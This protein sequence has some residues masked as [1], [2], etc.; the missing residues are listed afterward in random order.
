MY[1]ITND[2][3][4]E[5]NFSDERC[6]ESPLMAAD[7]VHSLARTST[8]RA[9][10]VC[11]SRCFV[12]KTM[13]GGRRKPSSESAA[14]VL[15][16]A[17]CR[18][19]PPLLCSAYYLFIT[20]SRVGT[21]IIINQHPTQRRLHTKFCKSFRR[22]KELLQ[23]LAPWL[24]R[25]R[26]INTSHKK[27]PIRLYRPLL[28]ELE[29]RT[30]SSRSRKESP[31][32][33]A[34]RR[35]DNSLTSDSSSGGRCRISLA[36]IVAL[37][38]QGGHLAEAFQTS[39]PKVSST[40]RTRSRPT[41]LHAAYSS[42]VE[43][44]QILPGLFGH[45]RAASTSSGSHSGASLGI[46]MISGAFQSN[47]MFLK[48]S[49]VSLQPISSLS[50]DFYDS[51]TTLTRKPVTEDTDSA[52]VSLQKPTRSRG[53]LGFAILDHGDH[54][55]SSSRV[56]IPMEESSTS[57]KASSQQEQQRPATKVDVQTWGGK[58][59]DSEWIASA[60]HRESSS[61]IL[62]RSP[63]S[64]STSGISSE[65]EATNIPA[66]FPWLPTMEQIK[67]LKVKELQ[68]VCGERGLKKVSKASNRSIR[69]SADE[70][71]VIPAGQTHST[72]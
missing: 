16:I 37:A 31:A 58:Q 1:V 67:E 57:L 54:I 53:V 2:S 19:L 66:W 15:R 9:M 40:S 22:S 63:S 23:S 12:L 72:V 18:S 45:D 32:S 13:G 56:P 8:W 28:L 70:L 38:F 4:L 17:D 44:P 52:D 62:N 21:A 27:K 41:H 25:P 39:L 51:T 43:E 24:S 42:S 11:F 34:D 69:D 10:D 64:S 55:I 5:P 50:S 46:S 35:H 49:R 61:P 14:P 29:I 6:D 65:N 48:S 47:Q 30:M 71:P 3:R 7:D 20:A 33:G 60:H 36:V 68:W 26:N 59:M